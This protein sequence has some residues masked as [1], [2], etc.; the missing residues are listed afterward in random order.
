MTRH[1]CTPTLQYLLLLALAGLVS[2][3]AA[4]HDSLLPI[5]GDGVVVRGEPAVSAG[6]EEFSFS[7]TDA[8]VLVGHDPAQ[9][10]TWV[11]VRGE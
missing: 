9:A 11:L 8:N 10:G 7:S 4:A 2:G 6:S 5:S 1:L 3:P